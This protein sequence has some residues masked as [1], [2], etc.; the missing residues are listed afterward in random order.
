MT[1]DSD[2]G[3]KLKS[4]TALEDYERELFVTYLAQQQQHAV[5]KTLM[6]SNP[7]LSL[8][9]P[10]RPLHASWWIGSIILSPSIVASGVDVKMSEQQLRAWLT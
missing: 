6:M 3:F 10:R 9:L 5:P 2:D 4:S 7:L 8:E 1:L